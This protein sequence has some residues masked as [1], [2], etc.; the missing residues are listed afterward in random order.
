MHAYFE[1][2]GRHFSHLIDP[3][4]GMPVAHATISATAQAGTC[5]QADALATVFML[6]A[7]DTA[8]RLADE[9]QVPA[10]LISREA[11]GYLLRRSARWPDDSPSP[12]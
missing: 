7:P 2:G 4:T 12:L 5:M 10:L 6:M 3:R 8:L 11:E 1:S 9:M